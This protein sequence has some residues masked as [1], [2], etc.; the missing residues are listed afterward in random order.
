[1]WSQFLW[2]AFGFGSGLLKIALAELA[3]ISERRTYLLMEGHDGL[4]KL[5]I[6]KTVINSGFVIPQYTSVALGSENKLLA[7]PSSVDSIPTSMGRKTT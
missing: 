3:S 6:E 4:P 2:S 5:L 7:H 1:M